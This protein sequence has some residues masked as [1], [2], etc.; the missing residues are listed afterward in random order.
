MVFLKPVLHCS[1][2]L[3]SSSF[4]KVATGTSNFVSVILNVA[5]VRLL[6]LGN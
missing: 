6:I 2:S 4:D 1:K 3:L 5:F